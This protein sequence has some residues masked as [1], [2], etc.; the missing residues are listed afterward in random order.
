M[1]SLDHKIFSIFFLMLLYFSCD[2]NAKETVID[3]AALY[4]K[5]CVLCHGADGKMGLNGAKELPLSQLTIGERIKIIQQ[6]KNLMPS[7]KE[8]LTFEQIKAIAEFTMQFK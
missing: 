4:K 2:H 7:F 5:K 8:Q 6:G 1:R 3:A